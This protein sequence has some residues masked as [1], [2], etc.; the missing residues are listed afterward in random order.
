MPQSNKIIT[1]KSYLK[2][3]A[4]GLRFKRSRKNK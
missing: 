2:S 1:R 3:V 4:K